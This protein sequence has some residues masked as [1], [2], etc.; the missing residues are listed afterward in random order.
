VSALI[1]VVVV[2]NNDSSSNNNNNN[3]LWMQAE[4]WCSIKRKGEKTLLETNAMATTATTTTLPAALIHASH[5]NVVGASD[6]RQIQ[7]AT[8]L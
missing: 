2:K 8:V 4:P 1:V 6:Q 7:N 5:T 3:N